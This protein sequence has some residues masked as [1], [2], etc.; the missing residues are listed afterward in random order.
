MT[1]MNIYQNS[2]A[3]KK[4]VL[5]GDILLSDRSSPTYSN[6]TCIMMFNARK[7]PYA[8]EAQ[9]SLPVHCVHKQVKWAL[10]LNR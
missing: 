3:D 7:G 2:L 9:I 8:K 10:Y 6:T 4:C 1:G 5:S